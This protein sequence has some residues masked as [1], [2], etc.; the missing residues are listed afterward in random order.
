MPNPV[1]SGQ[2]STTGRISACEMTDGAFHARVQGTASVSST[3]VISTAYYT[4]TIDTAATNSVTIPDTIGYKEALFNFAGLPTGVTVDVTGDVS[5]TQAGT[6]SVAMGLQSI[7]V[8]RS[9]TTVTTS[10]ANGT[11]VRDWGFVFTAL[12]LTISGTPAA[13]TLTYHV[14]LRK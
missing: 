6:Y 5:E 7:A 2:D 8:A 4:G 14:I 3:E 10:S 12:K 9:N 1:M 13:G 11:F